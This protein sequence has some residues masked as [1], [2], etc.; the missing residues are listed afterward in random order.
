ME[1]YW[2][3][4]SR[5]RPPA[6]TS[7]DAAITAIPQSHRWTV[8]TAFHSDNGKAVAGAIQNGTCL[9]G[10]DGSFKSMRSTSGF[11]LEGPEGETGRIYGT[12]AVPGAR[13]DQDFYHRELGGIMGVL[14]V[15]N[16]VAQLHCVRAGKL[17]LGLDGKGAME[18]SSLTR[19]VRPFDHSFDLLAEIRATYQR[20][21]FHVEFFLIEGHQTEQHGKEDYAGYLNRLCDNL[22]KAYWNETE[23][24]PAPESTLVNFT[25]S[26]FGYKNT[27][28]GQLDIE[29]VYNFTYGNVVSIPYLQAGRHPMPALGWIQVNWMVLGQAFRLWPRGKRQWMSN[30]MASFWATGRVMLRCK[31]WEHD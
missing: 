2:S 20:L 7:L 6:P 22:A 21:P 30:H 9:C 3:H 29:D 17:R 19:P 31:E 11:L 25:S 28:P 1:N 13:T 14:H 5:I 24:L 12:N 23:S 10:S 8:G 15:A 26:G 27:W 16:C 4:R 18:Q